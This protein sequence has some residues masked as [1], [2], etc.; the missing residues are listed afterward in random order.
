MQPLI[1]RFP[2]G[3]TPEHH[4]EWD[5]SLQFTVLS[6]KFSGKCISYLLKTKN[7]QLKT[8]RIALRAMLGFST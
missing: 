6:F 2:N 3:E 1:R 7:Y 8:S 5:A 4:I